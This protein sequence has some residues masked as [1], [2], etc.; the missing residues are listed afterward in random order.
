MQCYWILGTEIIL[1]VCPQI[2]TRL[3]ALMFCFET[4]WEVLLFSAFLFM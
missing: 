1:E 3:L 2:C 4:E